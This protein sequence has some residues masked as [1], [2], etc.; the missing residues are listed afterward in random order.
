MSSSTIELGKK[1]A[2]HLFGTGPWS[3]STRWNLVINNDK[4]YWSVSE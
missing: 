1:T 4:E 2:K 3:L